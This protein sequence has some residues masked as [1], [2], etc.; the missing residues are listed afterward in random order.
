MERKVYRF[1]IT[2]TITSPIKLSQFG[3][4]T[5]VPSSKNDKAK[6]I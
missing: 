4:I 6:V 2:K 5:K 1:Y 3:E